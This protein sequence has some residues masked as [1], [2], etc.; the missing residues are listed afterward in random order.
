MEAVNF[1]LLGEPDEPEQTTLHAPHSE[2]D[3]GGGSPWYGTL[4][5]YFYRQAAQP[6]ETKPNVQ[7]TSQGL[8]IDVTLS[9]SHWEDSDGSLNRNYAAAQALSASWRNEEDRRLSLPVSVQSSTNSTTQLDLFQNKGAFQPT[10]YSTSTS[11]SPSTNSPSGF[12]QKNPPS[13]ASSKSN[14]Q[15]PLAQNP[16]ANPYTTSFSLSCSNCNTQTTP[17]WRRDA[18]GLPVCNAC[19]LF[20]KLHGIPRPL[21]LKTEAFKKRKRSSCVSPGSGGRGRTRAE[22]NLARASK[23]DEVKARRTTTE[24][25][26]VPGE[27]TLDWDKE[28]ESDRIGEYERWNDDQMAAR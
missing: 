23:R 7:I 10:S 25:E 28:I 24:A 20:K 13:F 8:N 2:S 11:P 16:E 27:M 19:G 5:D 3:C 12:F 6:Q 26:P 18:D 21:S 15:I 17:L 14:S 4:P 22:K 9:G 1:A